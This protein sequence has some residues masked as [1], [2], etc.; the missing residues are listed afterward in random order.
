MATPALRAL[1]RIDITYLKS[2][3]KR[4][5]I[6]KGSVSFPDD[7]RV[8]RGR[9]SLCCREREREREGWGREEGGEGRERKEN[10]LGFLGKVVS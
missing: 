8:P 4:K 2:K 5:F 9:N 3:I 7:G 1:V 10:K 6:R